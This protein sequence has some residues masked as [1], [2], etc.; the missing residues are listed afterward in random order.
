MA[1]MTAIRAKTNTTA[2][3]VRRKAFVLVRPLRALLCDPRLIGWGSLFPF[4][5]VLNAEHF[6]LGPRA[7]VRDCDVSL[8]WAHVKTFYWSAHPGGEGPSE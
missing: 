8:G 6:A 2:A 3:S 5:F 1:I 7:S 4:A